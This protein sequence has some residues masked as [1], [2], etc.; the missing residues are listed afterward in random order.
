MATDPLT[1]EADARTFL[2]RA[3]AHTT[4]PVL[5]PDE[6]DDLVR[7]AGT[8]TDDLTME[9]SGVDLNRAASLGWQWKAGKVASDFTVSLTDGMKFNRAEVYEHCMV[10]SADFALGRKSVLGTSLP[11]RSRSGIGSVTLVS[12]MR[13]P[14]EVV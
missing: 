7:L 3:V 2:E 5:S 4:V 13:D 10:M 12:T 11:G 6:V 1:S 9:Y 14:D 8:L